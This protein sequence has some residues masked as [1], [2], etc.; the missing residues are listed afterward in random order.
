MSLIGGFVRPRR[1]T[2][3]ELKGKKKAKRGKTLQSRFVSLAAWQTAVAC[4]S[5]MDRN[6]ELKKT[7]ELQVLHSIWYAFFFFFF[8][9]EA[10]N[11][12]VNTNLYIQRC[13]VQ[14]YSV[15]TLYR[16]ISAGAP[17]HEENSAGLEMMY[18]VRQ[19]YF[20]I[21]PSK[22]KKKKKQTQTQTIPCLYDMI[23]TLYKVRC[24]ILICDT[25]LKQK[26]KLQRPVRNGSYAVP[27]LHLHPQF[28][29]CVEYIYHTL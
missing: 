4:L 17:R 28:S 12:V 14:R 27:H 11:S 5:L 23:I 13:S 21:P 26:V 8:F 3:A 25:N 16:A 19:M 1:D 10:F 18:R 6:Q 15:F 29:I 22:K 24:K 9:C 20:V 7:Y 2:C